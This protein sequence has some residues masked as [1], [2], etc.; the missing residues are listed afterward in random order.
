MKNHAVDFIEKNVD[1]VPIF[2]GDKPIKFAPRK[3]DIRTAEERYDEAKH[4]REIIF[5]QN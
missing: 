1:Q 2:G 5:Y 4:T 3:L